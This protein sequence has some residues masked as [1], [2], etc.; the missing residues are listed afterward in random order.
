ML[1][2]VHFSD[3]P[4]TSTLKL[5]FFGSK[6]TECV[7]LAYLTH[8]DTEFIVSRQ[9]EPPPLRMSLNYEILMVGFGLHDFLNGGIRVARS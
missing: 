2:Q 6:L 4:R 9:R 5:K 8:S 3:S 7:S 1:I